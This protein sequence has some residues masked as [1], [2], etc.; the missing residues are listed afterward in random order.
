M[1]TTS[2]A[3]KH[4]V[5]VTG[6]S[7]GLGAIMAERLTFEGYRVF[8]GVRRPGTPVPPGAI[9]VPLD[10]TVPASIDAAATDIAAQL[11]GGGLHALVNNAGILHAGPAETLTSE[12]IEAQLMTNVAGPLMTCQAFLPLLRRATG[13]IVNVG[14][15]N[16][17][18]PLPYWAVYSASKAALLALSDALRMEL[19]PWDIGVTVLTLGAFAT[20]VRRRAHEAWASDRAGHYEDARLTNA[21]LVAM[22][23]T[24]ASDP[25]LV[26]DELVAVLG[27][28]IAPAH[29]AVGEGVD[30]LLA[31][32][33]QPPDVRAAALAQL[34]E[35]QEGPP[36]S[37]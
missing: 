18:L 15:I 11:D 8:A 9:A 36:L 17:Q 21:R 24:T 20:D 28:D 5:V 27:A 32:G 14:S 1:S 13:R 37:R 3:A 2:T 7:R 12:Q 29:R 26:A 4:A 35:G 10:V 22:L 25:G 31:L 23:D 16:A 34:L 19:A 6:A 30:E 33:A